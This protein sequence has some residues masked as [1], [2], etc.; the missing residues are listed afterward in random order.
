VSA[1]EEWRFIQG[2]ANYEVSDLGRVRNT[3]SGRILKQYIKG[4]GG[5]PSVALSQDG[6]GAM[7]YRFV[8]RLIMIAFVGPVP[9]AMQ[10]S[11]KD[12]DRMNSVLSNLCY[13]TASEN[14]QRKKA[15]GTHQAGERNPAAKFTWAMVDMIRGSPLT[16]YRFAKV[17]NLPESRVEKI[18]YG[19]TWKPESRPAA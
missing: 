7:K 9:D 8:H 2:F 1:V 4:G 14:N 17:H 12:N 10:V 3:R 19:V 6:K 11:H 13:E 5:Y 18:K 15:H 16:A